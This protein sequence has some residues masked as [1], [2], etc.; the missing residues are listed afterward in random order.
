LGIADLISRDMK[1]LRVLAIVLV[2]GCCIAADPTWNPGDAVKEAEQDI[3]S[4]HIKFYW[5]GSIASRPVGV[6]IEVAK[7]YPQAN[8][9]IGCV[10]ND[11]PL[12]ERQEEYA[13]RYNEKMFA[14]V[15]QKH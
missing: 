13:R 5:A 14:Y 12:R 1:M 9:G 8:A 11:I 10:T 4:G 6:P 15:S 2:G 3:R 7:K